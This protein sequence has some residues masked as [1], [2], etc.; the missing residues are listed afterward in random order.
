MRKFFDSV[1]NK[2]KPEKIVTQENTDEI[3]V[4]LI[5]SIN[6]LTKKIED[7]LDELKQTNFEIMGENEKN[8]VDQDIS[9]KIIVIDKYIT[10]LHTITLSIINKAKYQYDEIFSLLAILK[11]IK[12]K[13][14]QFNKKISEKLLISQLNEIKL[15]LKEIK[16]K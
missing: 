11:K 7:L 16:L 1:F 14:L 2:K 3:I 8:L 5:G 9:K 4:R 12:A 6:L 13:N 10:Y 15:L